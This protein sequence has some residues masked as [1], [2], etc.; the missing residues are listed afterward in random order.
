M[1]P[2]AREP[3]PLQTRLGLWDTAS[4]IVGIIIGVGIFETPAAVFAYATGLWTALAIW[5]LAGLLSLVGAFCFAE[6]ASTYPR[7]GGE[8]VYLTRAYGPRVGFL[9]AWA[10]LAVIRTGGSIA[11]VAYLFAD[12][13]GVLWPL[14]P[15][16]KVLL[17]ILA[18]AVLSLV[19][20]L[21]VRLGKQTQ[22]VLTASKLAGLGAIILVGFV[23]ANPGELVAR[24]QLVEAG[25]GT[26]VLDP[27]DGSQHTL[28]VAAGA[29][30]VVDGTVRTE[31]GLDERLAV[32]KP[33]QQVRVLTRPGNPQPDIR[34]TTSAPVTRLAG[35][36]LAMILV[37]WTYAGWHEGAY[38]AAEVE[39]RRRNLPLALILG[40]GVVL[41]L[42]LLINLAYAVGL[43]YEWAAGAPTV[44]ADVL[45]L[46]PWG[47]AEQTMAV[48]FMVSA[49][50]AINGMIFTSSRIYTE[51]GADH[52]LFAPL[53]RWNRRWGTPVRSLVVQAVICIVM[54]TVV[55][56]C[57]EGSGFGVLVKCTAPVFCVFFFLT[58]T[59]LIVLRFK[60]PD[61]ERPFVTPAYPLTPLLFCSFWGFM[62]VGSILYAPVE[63]A[64]GLGILVAGMPLYLLSRGWRKVEKQEE[65]Q[66][67]IAR[68]RDEGK[69]L[70]QC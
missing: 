23:W 13:A 20:I 41:L 67:V 29:R 27:G 34:A 3:R 6:L 66:P 44:A 40:T 35:L 22:N 52:R 5:G 11:A 57:F 16:A 64:V 49:L 65:P 48:L 61:V 47:S 7:S 25:Q 50:G 15:L 43:G 28:S 10:Q 9:F 39:H 31:G 59:S 24:G 14:A 12:Y 46:L 18:I 51:L 56:L 68:A 60:E 4:I 38:V 58:G 8:Y 70:T 53:G 32:L 26:L 30:V 55:G 42:Y 19:N 17:A 33:G 54:A 62:L 63:A 45:G 69:Q 21:G 36:A 37:L 2:S 1:E